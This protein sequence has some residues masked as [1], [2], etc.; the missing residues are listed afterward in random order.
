[1]LA[2][3]VACALRKGV[4]NVKTIFNLSLIIVIFLLLVACSSQA[5]TFSPLSM[6]E[7]IEP[8]RPEVYTN[9]FPT[10]SIDVHRSFNWNGSV[11]SLRDFRDNWQGAT[12]NVSNTSS[13]FAM[14]NVSISARGRGNSTWNNMGVKRPIRFRFP[15][16]EW[17]PMFDSPH[18]GRDWVLF[19]N[20]ID[21]AHLRNFA[22]FYLGNQLE[23]FHFTPQAWFV[24]L[25]L[26]RSYRGV[27]LLV[28]ERE[29]IPGRGDLLIDND[30]TISEY[31]LEF[32]MHSKST[33]VNSD[34]VNVRG[35]WEIRY[36]SSSALVGTVGNPHALYVRDFLTRVN[37]VIASNDREAF[38]SL[39]DLDSFIDF[40]L[41]NELFGNADAQFSSMFY[42]IRGQGENRRLYSGPLW[43]FDQSSGTVYRTENPHGLIVADATGTRAVRSRNGAMDWYVTLVQQR[44]FIQAVRERWSE[45][46]DVEVVQMLDR[47]R[48]MA[49]TFEEEFIRDNNR[50]PAHLN[51]VW[52]T[53]DTVAGLN[54]S[55]ENAQFLYW[56]LNQRINWLNVW[57]RLVPTQRL[58]VDF[59]LLPE[60]TQTLTLINGMIGNDFKPENRASKIYESD[61]WL[62]DIET[63]TIVEII[64]NNPGEDYK[65]NHWI[66]NVE[67]EFSDANAAETTFKMPATDVIIEAIFEPL[68][69]L[70][71]TLTII[72]GTGSSDFETE[73]TI[74]D[75]AESCE[76]DYQLA[77]IETDN[78]AEIVADNL[79]T[80]C[81]CD[82]WPTEVEADNI[83][84]IVAD[85][86]ATSCECDYQ[87]AE[88]DNITEIVA[89]NVV[90]SCECDCQPAE[91]E[92]D[93]TAE[94]V[95]DNLVASCECDCQPAEIETDNIAEIA[96][97]N[98][99]TSDE[100]AYQI[101]DIKTDT[102]VKI[103]ANNPDEG[104]KF[105]HW[106]ANVE[107]EFTDANAV[108]TTL[109]MPATDVIIE[110][111][112]EPLPELTHT[113]TI[114][115]GTKICD[116]ETEII[117]NNGAENCKC[118]YWETDI[119]TDTIVKIKANNP[120]E[121]YKFSH[122][123]A[124]VEIEFADVNAVATT[125][126]MPATDVIIEAIFEPLPD[127]QY[128]DMDLENG[129]KNANTIIL[130][131]NEQPRD[132][133]PNEQHE[134]W[135]T[136]KLRRFWH[137]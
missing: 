30:P 5:R 82:Y 25:Y 17:Q 84:E 12:L 9:G 50:W 95:A 76:C 41:I 133:K 89:D 104:Y 38:E 14:N 111:I 130:A 83:A 77:E 68:P 62:A 125:F 101:A 79:V 93:N 109:K 73:I 53:S 29:A 99:A 96:T 18:V 36:P 4:Q 119:K 60:T 6:P 72:N 108:V 132:A 131:T 113:L 64:A 107:I 67:I 59:E 127:Q 31:M 103:K 78:T 27:Y 90:A 26:D 51:R 136:F 116:F 75:V 42:Q 123:I 22:A 49:L 85:N 124:N 94:I 46:K 13:Q 105:S 63:A 21:P 2:L 114:I 126:K 28:D 86:F 61:H 52:R 71:H 15:N 128:L 37:D 69:E 134:I 97:D 16:N 43:D 106:I 117:T 92:T 47:V 45:I 121:G 100:L 24:H 34:W 66:A 54:S 58:S 23:S 74:D 110:A 112:F 35:Q 115:N 87:S 44:W 120:D 3:F 20:V 137:I 10:L 40:Y 135:N 80:S 118:D 129:S 55:L 48:Y 11:R 7:N 70:T 122:W 91:I 32:D 88:I 65:F 57:L 56:W 102:I 33:P 8:H 98:L 19:A 81:E 39:I 1:M